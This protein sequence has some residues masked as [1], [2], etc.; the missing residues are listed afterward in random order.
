MEISCTNSD[1]INHYV[2]I[3]GYGADHWIIRNSMK[4]TWGISGD[5]LISFDNGKDGCI[6]DNVYSA[7]IA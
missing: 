1:D 7:I 2:L 6:A 3:I 5:A 4:S